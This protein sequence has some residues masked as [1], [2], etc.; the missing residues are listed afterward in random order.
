MLRIFTFIFLFSISSG[1]GQTTLPNSFEQKILKLNDSFAY[2]TAITILNTYI[3]EHKTEPDLLVKAYILK[4]QTYKRLFNY[5]E[6]LLT[7][8][9]AEKEAFKSPNK[10][11]LLNCV[12]AEMAFALFDVHKYS[13]S[14]ALMKKLEAQRFKGLPTISIIFLTMQ[15]GY[16]YFLDKHYP[17]AEQKLNQSLALAEHHSPRDVP[18]ILAKHMELYAAMGQMDKMEAAFQK[19]LSF[20]QRF[21]IV[22]YELYLYE[23]RKKIALDSK[24]YTRFPTFQRAFDSLNTLYNSTQKSIKVSLLEKELVQQK[25][26][27]QKKY[28]KTFQTVLVVLVALLAALVFM[29]FKYNL[30][31]K[32]KKELAQNENKRIY[33]EL[34]RLT[35]SK[36]KDKLDLTQF[37]LTDRQ[38]EI[39]Q[40]LKEGKTNKEIGALLFISENTVKYHLKAIYEILNIANRSE[41]K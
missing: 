28:Q 31:N 32:T 23:I 12:H 33:D 24:D 20:A 1:I 15:E 25:N 4:S 19:G 34:M 27:L 35:S 9:Y 11:I 36:N 7:L 13:E 3:E 30:V 41:L 21:K 38:L 39:I 10:Q 2:E 6:V 18:N 8:A 5:E 29:L 26:D 17:E 37:D 22:K 40:Y 14:N 16:L